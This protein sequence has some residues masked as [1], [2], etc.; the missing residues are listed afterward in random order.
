ML[1][2]LFTP[3]GFKVIGLRNFEFVARTQFSY[4][5]FSNLDFVFFPLANNSDHRII[6]LESNRKYY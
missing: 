5:C 6:A 1:W 4:N 2:T 3:S